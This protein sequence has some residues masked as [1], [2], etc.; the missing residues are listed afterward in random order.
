V[1]IPAARHGKRDLLQQ[2]LTEDSAEDPTHERVPNEWWR[3][4]IATIGKRLRFM[5]EDDPIARA[6]QHFR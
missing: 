1:H 3:G 5:Q 6:V 4:D 2:L